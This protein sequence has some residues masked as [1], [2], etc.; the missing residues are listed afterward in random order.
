VVRIG[1]WLRALVG[2]IGV[3][4]FMAFAPTP[5]L[6]ET[7]LELD[8]TPIA[9][10][11]AEKDP[12]VAVHVRVQRPEW[13]VTHIAA[14]GARYERSSQYWMHD[15]TTANR[16]SWLGTL[17][18]R[19]Y[20]EMIGRLVPQGNTFFYEEEIRDGRMG[21]AATMAT[22]AQ[23]GPA[24]P[25]AEAPPVAA[26]TPAA[27]SPE[28]PPRFSETQSGTFSVTAAS[29]GG[30]WRVLVT[31]M[32][33][34]DAGSRL[35]AAVAQ[36]GID[37][38]AADVVLN[39][40]GGSLPG[41]LSLGRAIRDLRFDTVLETLSDT[42]TCYSACAYAFLGGVSR[43]VGAGQIG[44]HEFAPVPGAETDSRTSAAAQ[45]SQQLMAMIDAYLT[46]MGVSHDLLSL[47]AKV[48]PSQT[49]GLSHEEADELRVN[50]DDQNSMI[51]WTLAP[52]PTGLVMRT[53]SATGAR[54]A[55]LACAGGG[56]AQ[57]EL[58]WNRSGLQKLPAEGELA[59]ADPKFTINGVDSADATETVDDSASSLVISF[60][61]P[62]KDAR[63]LIVRSDGP[64][65]GHFHAGVS[66]NA[67]HQTFGSLMMSL[68]T[69]G[70]RADLDI[71]IASC[72]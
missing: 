1:G 20:V 6:A 25:S 30:R 45:T 31:G 52:W 37:K 15:A 68:P 61:M 17:I 22:R 27:P 46:E 3:L 42:T 21:G 24:G 5:A 67:A 51:R 69:D 41:G 58:R 54:E 64:D 8:C 19:P 39:S 59:S 47:G 72:H 35:R 65:D 18:D 70:L 57:L 7:A 10:P 26:S 12:I 44:F 38:H 11:T 28:S 62:T 66:G 23:C 9:I 49:R 50:F 36:Y 71:L 2:F 4:P 56:N 55:S 13:R 34:A 33:P 63:A 40:S 14:S 16:L 29:H 53:E 48:G 32:I 60:V 43:R